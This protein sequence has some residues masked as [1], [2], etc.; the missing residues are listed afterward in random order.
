MLTWLLASALGGGAEPQS[1]EACLEVLAGQDD[2]A[3]RICRMDHPGLGRV[4]DAFVRITGRPSA[5][6][7]HRTF[8]LVDGRRM[9][10]NHERNL[11]MGFGSRIRVWL[12]GD[13]VTQFEVPAGRYAHAP[14][15]GVDAER[16]VILDLSDEETATAL[17]YD[18][19][20]GALIHRLSPGGTIDRVGI[21]AGFVTVRTSAGHHVFDADGT[22]LWTVAGGGQAPPTLLSD[23]SAALAGRAVYF[24]DGRKVRVPYESHLVADTLF[25]VDGHGDLWRGPVT[26]AEGIVPARPSGTSVLELG[27]HGAW[28]W[29]R[30][31]LAPADA[32]PT[33]RETPM[34]VSPPSGMQTLVLSAEEGGVALV[35]AL[36]TDLIVTGDLPEPGVD[37]VIA[38]LIRSRETVVSSVVLKPGTS[39]DLT[40]RADRRFEVQLGRVRQTVGAFAGQTSRSFEAVDLATAQQVAGR[41][42]QAYVPVLVVDRKGRPV[43]G[44]AVHLAKNG[45]RVGVTDA[46]GRVHLKV[47]GPLVAVDDAGVSAATTLEADG[48]RLVIDAPLPDV[49]WVDV[50]GQVVASGPV[51]RT[52]PDVAFE[53]ATITKDGDGTWVV[54]EQTT[55]SV[56]TPV[57]GMYLTSSILTDGAGVEHDV[58]GLRR[59]GISPGPAR[60]RVTI[61]D[62]AWCADL[63][64]SLGHNELVPELRR[65]E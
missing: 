40:L 6:D 15:V 34:D 5:P 62:A 10:V 36:G 19:R 28:W 1:R 49:R 48:G 21:S 51:G 16:L 43:A 41:Y 60:L 24:R 45:S 17:V 26:E 35:S 25:A 18:H 50:H 42:G 9:W 3:K 29:M 8:V 27:P 53:S 30:G 23:G 4:P 52:V 44:A 33:R 47:S 39:R 12:E 22:L 57:A 65:C 38:G 32:V 55:V 2:V 20:T 13:G 54:V 64:V 56:S 46:D 61:D 63:T 31:V 37:G 59:T 11:P 14:V 58:R 7:G